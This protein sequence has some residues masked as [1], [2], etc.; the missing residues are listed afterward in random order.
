MYAL[1]RTTCHVP[2][3]LMGRRKRSSERKETSSQGK[4]KK[5]KEKTVKAR[6]AK[7]SSTQEVPMKITVG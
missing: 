6:L 4:K 5:K 2:G 3:F 1:L 7:N